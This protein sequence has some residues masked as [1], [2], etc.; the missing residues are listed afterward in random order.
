MNTMI[1]NNDISVFREFIQ[2]YTGLYFPETKFTAIKKMIQSLLKESPCSGV[3]EFILYL[4]TKSGETH[5]KKVISLLTTNE[6]YFFRGKSYFDALEKYLLPKIIE[7]ET[8]SSKTISIWSAGCS[9]GE[10]PYSIAILLKSMIPQ[11][12]E[13]QIEIIGTD[14]DETALESAERGEYGEWS[15]R[16]LDP[17]LIHRAF[18][19]SGEI[20]RINPAYRSL[21]SFRQHNLIADPAPRLK[22]QDQKFDIIF[23]RNVTI[24]FDKETT[25]ALS[26]KFFH[27]LQDKGYLVVGDSEH[28]AEIYALYKSRTF[29]D[30]IIYQKECSTPEINK[31]PYTEKQKKS[32]SNTLYKKEQCF[33]IKG[34]DKQ[35]G[36]K[37]QPP[38]QANESTE[39]NVLVE[40]NKIFKQAMHAYFNKE[41]EWAID[42]F[43]R[44]IAL[45]PKNAITCWMI[46]HIFSNRGDFEEAIAWS[47]RAI[48][49]NPKLKEP[50]YT[51]A[52]IHLA[53]GTLNDARDNILKALQ[54][55]RDFVLGHH[56]KGSICHL[57]NL[58]EQSEDAFRT[59]QSLLSSKATDEIIFETEFLAVDMLKKLIEQ[60][61]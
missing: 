44:I 58:K 46:S 33:K 53:Q 13:W 41:Y 60:K 38:T 7:R 24:Y 52:T 49:N 28:S 50:Y 2:G 12:K 3:K 16:G 34:L 37:H 26:K 57:M 48:R 21:I 55:D 15:F 39:S 30:A 8:R 18:T 51:L 32:F 19:K 23:C 43:L 11:I 22:H 17:A 47:K 45:N 1:E 25:I 29:P 27:T 9:S 42:R 6:T 40:A 61:V 31:K 10:E 59:A 54:I 4:K 20:Y 56:L 36:K 35:R 14:L 5:L